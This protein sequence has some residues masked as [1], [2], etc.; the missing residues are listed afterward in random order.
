MTRLA[1]L[2]CVAFLAAGCGGGEAG[3]LTKEEFVAQLDQICADFNAKQEEIGDPESL[4]DIVEQ[5]PRVQDEFEAAIERIRDLGDPP[6]E[7]AEDADRFLEIADESQRLI[8]ELVEA[9]EDDDLQRA[10]EIAE[11]GDALNEESEEIATELGAE[12]CAE[13]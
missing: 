11:E 12:N 9:A 5:G 8:G 7:I 6:A 2:G 13:S 4:E 1:L 10:G 3:G